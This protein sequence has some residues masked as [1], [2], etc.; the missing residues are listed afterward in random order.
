[1]GPSV[2]VGFVAAFALLA[3]Y[4]AGGLAGGIV[5]RLPADAPML[6]AP[7]CTHCSQPVTSTARWLVWAS[8]C[9][10]CGTRLAWSFHVVRWLGAALAAGAFL[11]YGISVQALAVS[12]FSLWLLPILWIDWRRHEIYPVTLVPAGALALLLAAFDSLGSVVRALAGGALATALFGLFFVIGLVLYRHA[13]LG[14]GDIFLAGL[15]GLFVGVHWVMPALIL[16]MALAAISGLGQL[17]LR[18]RSRHDFLPYGS[19]LCIGAMIA[20]FLWGP[21]T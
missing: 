15:I 9:S 13:A 10:T 8:R 1:M 7:I 19:Y 2:M 5:T 21:A 4:A 20:L 14:A 11:R 3:G 16:G 18:V 6:G 17:A 12:L